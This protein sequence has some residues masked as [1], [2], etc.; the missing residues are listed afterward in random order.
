M[1]MHSARARAGCREGGVRGS[2][3]RPGTG[4]GRGRLGRRPPGSQRSGGVGARG[5]GSGA[6]TRASTRGRFRVNGPAL[7]GGPARLAHCRTRPASSCH[8]WP[9]LGCALARPAEARPRVRLEAERGPGPLRPSRLGTV[10]PAGQRPPSGSA[11]HLGPAWAPREGALRAGVCFQTVGPR[12]AR[13]PPAAARLH[14]SKEEEQSPW[15]RTRLR[16]VSHTH[17][18]ARM[19]GAEASAH[20]NPG[21]PPSPPRF[22]SKPFVGHRQD[23]R[24]GDSSPPHSFWHPRPRGD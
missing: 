8:L 9:T 23:R 4:P 19:M 1:N 18:R 2:E 15:I 20:G 17:T 14:P 22:P 24:V 13:H 16:A 11:P 7:C 10:P 5:G 12:A 6:R 3:P 21:P